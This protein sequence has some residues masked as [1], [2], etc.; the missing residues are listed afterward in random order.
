MA[1]TADDVQWKEDYCLGDKEVDTGRKKLLGLADAFLKQQSLQDEDA[2]KSEL[3]YIIDEL[4]FYISTHFLVE[5]EFFKTQEYHHL[6]EHIAKHKTIVSHYNAFLANLG[7]LSLEEVES[8]LEAILEKEFIHHTTVD[9]C[10]FIQWDQSLESFAKTFDWHEEFMIK[11]EIIDKHNQELFKVATEA[12]HDA[13]C[14][15]TR[16]EK[17]RKTINFIY[18][19]LKTSF[20]QEEALMKEYRYPHIAKHILRHRNII[21]QMNRLAMELPHADTAYFEKQLAN[22]LEATFVYHVMDED[23]NLRKW[24]SEAR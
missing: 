18:E 7:S 1:F 4:S 11:D 19:Y 3:K 13:P 14:C 12:F 24:I 2:K 21:K 23:N 8:N 20:R 22:L 5:Q 17:I 15:D 6:D 16:D 10:E 9:D